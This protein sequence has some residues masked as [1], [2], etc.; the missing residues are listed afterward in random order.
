MLQ[1]A[2]AADAPTLIQVPVARGEEASPWE[3][4][5]PKPFARDAG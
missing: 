3:F 1:K 4:V 5:S 2:L